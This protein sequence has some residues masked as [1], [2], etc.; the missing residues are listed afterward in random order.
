MGHAYRIVDDL[1]STDPPTALVVVNDVTAIYLLKAVLARGLRVPDDV[2][3]TGFD[4][5]PI[6][7]HLEV[8]L[9]TVE[10][11]FHEIGRRAA[12]ML[13]H[14]ISKPKEPA[15]SEALPTRLVVRRSSGPPA[16]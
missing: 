15:R 10:Q 16:G 8:P 1:F 2:T 11:P 4:N 7:E 6:T 5:L 12:D 14:R 13:I 3:V 9:T